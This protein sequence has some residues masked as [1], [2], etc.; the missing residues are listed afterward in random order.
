[1]ILASDEDYSGVW[2]VDGKHEQVVAVILYYFNKVNLIGGDLEFIGKDLHGSGL[3]E[4]SLYWKNEEGENYMKKKIRGIPSAKVPITKGT[5]VVFS[6]YQNLHR[7]LRMETKN[8]KNYGFRDFLAF[9]VVDQRHNLQTSANRPGHFESPVP[10]QPKNSLRKRRRVREGL[11]A[12]QLTARKGGFDL[13]AN[14]VYSTGNGSAAVLGFTEE[15]SDR[16]DLSFD[17]HNLPT[18]MDKLRVQALNKKPPLLRGISW[19]GEKEGILYN[20]HSPWIQVNRGDYTEYINLING[21]KR[22]V[23]CSNVDDGGSG[24]ENTNEE[25]KKPKSDRIPWKEGVSQFLNDW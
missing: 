22:T 8:K 6:N 25:K 14:A 18:S 7:V 4:K 15:V 9:F 11:L 23:Y 13:N 19:A 1:M 21:E 24:N 2:H 5:L 3:S 20:E 12:E 10:R 17:D 16:L